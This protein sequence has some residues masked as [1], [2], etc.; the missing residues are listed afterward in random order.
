MSIP[1]F[2]VAVLYLGLTTVPNRVM[3]GPCTGHGNVPFRL[4]AAGFGP[5]L[6]ATGFGFGD[7]FPCA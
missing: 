5:G 6:A 3:T 7:D 1:E 2:F 4:S